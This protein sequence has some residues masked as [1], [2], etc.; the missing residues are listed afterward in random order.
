MQKQFRFWTGCLFFF[1]SLAQAESININHTKTQLNDYKMK[2]EKLQRTLNNARNKQAVFNA[3]LARTDKE[4]GKGLTEL[5]AIEK[6]IAEKQIEITALQDKVKQLTVELKKQQQLVT[7]YAIH[8]YKMGEYQ[9]LKWLL[10][11]KNPHTF[12]RVLTYYHYIIR[13]H[14]NLIIKA[15]ETKQN[16]IFN[17]EALDRE[18]HN[19]RQLQQQLTTRQHKLKEEKLYQTALIRSLNKDIHTAKQTLEEYKQNQAHL[20]QLLHSFVQQNIVQQQSPFSSM[21]HKLPAPIAIDKNTRKLNHGLIFYAH[22]GQPIGAVYPGKVV[23]SDWL[24][25]YGLLLIIDHGQGFMTLYAHNQSIL[26]Q[27]GD[28][29]HQNEQIATVGHSGGLI[30]NGLYFE[31]RHRGKA[32]PPLEWLS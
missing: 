2:I 12:N 31:V 5:L 1:I 26:K 8:R 7:D 3:E 28:V 23:F 6:H 22:E 14:Q 16:L 21:R 30:Q 15:R 29:V 10:N 17:T 13:Y 24:K 20:A 32:I 4:I 19:Q 27:K 18:I 11:Q 25:G 9:P